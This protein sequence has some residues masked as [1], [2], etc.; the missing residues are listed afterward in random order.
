MM[1]DFALEPA[2]VHATMTILRD[3]ILDRLDWIRIWYVKK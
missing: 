1:M 2:Y 3:V